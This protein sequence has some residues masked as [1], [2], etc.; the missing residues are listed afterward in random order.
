L[1]SDVS[2]VLRIE[3]DC[4]K[5]PWDHSTFKFLA[6]NHGLI[7]ERDEETHM[8]VVTAH[9]IIVAYVVWKYNLHTKVGH[10]LNI[11]VDK[12]HRRKGIARS[13]I[14]R[15][16]SSLIDADANACFLEVRESN[17]GAQEF[18]KEMKMTPI[19]R[20]KHYYVDEDA[21]IFQII[22]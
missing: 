13:L 5:Y 9:S 10:L 1:H 7:L 14:R 22:F 17:I 20:R 3:I 12:E 8:L 4:F 6:D 21:I 11:A 16:F 2:E 15:M 19:N 18:Y